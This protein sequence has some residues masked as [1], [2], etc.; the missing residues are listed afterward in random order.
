MSIQDS[1]LGRLSAISPA[2]PG[3]VRVSTGGEV[4]W[5][6]KEKRPIV[7]S[8]DPSTPQLGNKDTEYLL[9][10]AASSPMSIATQR[11]I[12]IRDKSQDG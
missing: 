2:L 1:D 5:S 8:V 9:T 6:A 10:L 7:A 12:V 4:T 11:E 3:G